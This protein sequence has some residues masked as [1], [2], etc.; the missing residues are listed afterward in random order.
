LIEP[1]SWELDIAQGQSLDSRRNMSDVMKRRTRRP[2]AERHA[3]GPMG[4]A[5]DIG[6]VKSIASSPCARWEEIEKVKADA[7][8][9]S[10]GKKCRR[11]CSG[12]IPVRSRAPD[13]GHEYGVM[14]RRSK[15]PGRRSRMPPPHPPPPPPPRDSLS[16]TRRTK[17]FERLRSPPAC[18]HRRDQSFAR[19]GDET[20]V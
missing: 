4:C 18:R 2:S 15:M 8:R 6:Y 9:R 19:I 11:G 16:G 10:R 20:V 3:T 17:L 14:A 12:L 1:T 13:L 7:G 5:V